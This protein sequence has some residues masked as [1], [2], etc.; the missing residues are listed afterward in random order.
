M[1]ALPPIFTNYDDLSGYEWLMMPKEKVKLQFHFLVP[2]DLDPSRRA[3]RNKKKNAKH[4]L[5]SRPHGPIRE[6]MTNGY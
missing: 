5:F 3:R 2:N 4:M 1:C 6:A